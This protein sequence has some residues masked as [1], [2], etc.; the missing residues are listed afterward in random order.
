LLVYL[1]I[2]NFWGLIAPGILLFL[3]AGT[4]MARLR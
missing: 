1:I 2:G 4:I 3:G